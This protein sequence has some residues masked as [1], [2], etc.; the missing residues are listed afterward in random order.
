MRRIALVSVTALLAACGQEPAKQPPAKAAV[1]TAAADQPQPGQYR[2]TMTV[3]AISIPGMSS[4]MAE[5]SKVMF[6]GTG[7]ISDF[8]LT[9]EQAKK[10]REEFTKYSTEGNCDYE[11]FSARDG[12]IDGVMVCQTGQGMSAR[13]E[14]SGT[15]TKNQSDLTLKTESRVPGTSGGMTMNSRIVMERIGDCT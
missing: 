8:C 4:A 11:R 2:V 15:F 13:T 14:M 9:P 3:N 5:K 1:E 12:K 10:G 6:G 7:Q